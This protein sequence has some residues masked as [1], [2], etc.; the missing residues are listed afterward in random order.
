M[1]KKIKILLSKVGLDT[2]ERGLKV[3]AH[4]LKNAGMEVIYLGM[5]QSPDSIISAALQEDVDV[6]GISC[7]S[8]EHF[9]A[10]EKIVALKKQRG[11]EDVLFILGGTLPVEQVP[12]LKEI[13]VDEV[14]RSGSRIGDIVEYI[15]GNVKHVSER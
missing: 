7:L 14:F 6:I 13:G 3:I 15:E 8:G 11:L 12:K 9:F 2:H 5:Y 4:N 1:K 10:S